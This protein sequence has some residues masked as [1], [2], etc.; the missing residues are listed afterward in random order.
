M[1]NPP[2]FGD[3]TA[4]RIGPVTGGE[5]V[6]ALAPDLFRDITKMVDGGDAREILCRFRPV[7]ESKR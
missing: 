4:A 6:L 7:R 5:T 3:M 1:P 2:K